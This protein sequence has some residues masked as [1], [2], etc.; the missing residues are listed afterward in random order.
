MLETFP[1]IFVLLT[2]LVVV[3]VVVLDGHQL[4]PSV[5]WTCEGR[6]DLLEL[7]ELFDFL[8]M[9]IRCDDRLRMGDCYL[10]EQS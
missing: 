6:L 10:T 2:P 8:A 3:L 9:M 4:R 7:V 5:R 1:I